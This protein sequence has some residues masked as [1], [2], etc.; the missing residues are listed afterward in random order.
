M[1]FEDGVRK[2]FGTNTNIALEEDPQSLIDLYSEAVQENYESYSDFIRE[3][4][5]KSQEVTGL[6][7][8]CSIENDVYGQAF[9]KLS[10]MYLGEDMDIED[11]YKAKVNSTV[12]NILSDPEFDSKRA[13]EV[14]FEI[15]RRYNIEGEAYLDGDELTENEDGAII[16]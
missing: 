7:N 9:V 3:V 5:N 15:D 13:A 6:E 1:G 4:E 14:G 11:T 8:N 16:L 12:S 2:G 10:R